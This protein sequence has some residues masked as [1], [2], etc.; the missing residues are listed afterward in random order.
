MFLPASVCLSFCLSASLLKKLFTDFGEM[1]WRGG[2]WPKDK[3]LD[4]NGDLD[5]GA[6]P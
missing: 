4:F 5:Y 3:C 6:N 2:V 1:F